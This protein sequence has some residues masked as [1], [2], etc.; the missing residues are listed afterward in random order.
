[1]VETTKDQSEVLLETQRTTHAVRAI[2]RFLILEVTYGVVGALL[3]ALGVISLTVA[4]GGGLAGILILGGAGTIVAGLIHS[5]Q[6]GWDELSKSNRLA[7]PFAP[8]GER[9]VETTPA[10]AA[11]FHPVAGK[12]E[13][14]KWERGS[15]NTQIHNEV[16]YCGR[17]NKALE[18]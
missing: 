15:G 8:A 18:S 11:P 14:S 10:A 9:L 17:C 2:A 3:I 6:A 12:C 5:L 7:P 13:C 1:M 16:E 4:D